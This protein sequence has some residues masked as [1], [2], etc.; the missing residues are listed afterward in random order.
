MIVESW[1]YKSIWFVAGH[2]HGPACHSGPCGPEGAASSSL[3]EFQQKAAGGS[4]QA[5]AQLNRGDADVTINWSGGLHHAKKSG[6]P[7]R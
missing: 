3:F 1:F 2:V 5:A 4:L 7:T 6:R